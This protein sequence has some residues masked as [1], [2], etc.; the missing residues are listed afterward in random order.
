[1]G[2][3]NV[4]GDADADGDACAGSRV[5]EPVDTGGKSVVRRHKKTPEERA[6]DAVEWKRMRSII[7][8]LRKTDKFKLRQKYQESA[9]V[10]LRHVPRVSAILFEQMRTDDILYRIRNIVAVCFSYLKIDRY[11]WVCLE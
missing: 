10:V 3:T 5:L 4:D 6:A 8:T 7:D 1:M 11:V 2:S 9:W